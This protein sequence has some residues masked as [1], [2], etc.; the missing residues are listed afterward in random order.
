MAVGGEGRRWSLHIDVRVWVGIGGVV[1][2]ESEKKR[3]VE[4][5]NRKNEKR[6]GRD[7]AEYLFVCL[8]WY[9]ER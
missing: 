4:I 8:L 2:K 1:G 3:E 6:A 9:A 7:G 5:K